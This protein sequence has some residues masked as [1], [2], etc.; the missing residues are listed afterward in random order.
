MSGPMKSILSQLS[1]LSAANRKSDITAE[2]YRH[3]P[4]HTTNDL[5]SL[6]TQAENNRAAVINDS[7]VHRNLCTSNNKSLKLQ[8]QLIRAL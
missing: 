3:R 4:A 7:F 6:L 2:E 1:E 8:K 5:P